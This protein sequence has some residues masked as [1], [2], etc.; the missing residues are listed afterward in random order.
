MN[1]SPAM[2]SRNLPFYFALVVAVTFAAGSFWSAFGPRHFLLGGF[3]VLAVWARDHFAGVFGE[4]DP[5][6]D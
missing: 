5:D 4:R 2:S 6:S 1:R 3:C